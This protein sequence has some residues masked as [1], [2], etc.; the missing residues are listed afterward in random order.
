LSYA[1]AIDDECETGLEPVGR[2]WK[3]LR[4]APDYD[5]REGAAR[6]RSDRQAAVGACRVVVNNNGPA[7]LITPTAIPFQ[8]LNVPT[9]LREMVE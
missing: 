2:S 3:R 9:R 1:F 7:L 6:V 5:F 4:Q 8:V